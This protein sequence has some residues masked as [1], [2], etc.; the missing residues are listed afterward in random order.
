MHVRRTKKKER[1][2]KRVSPFPGPNPT[3][4]LTLTLTLS[5]TLSPNHLA[6]KLLQTTIPTVQ[7]NI[8]YH[9]NIQQGA[10]GLCIINKS[11]LTSRLVKL[12][13]DV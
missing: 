4:T 5:L 1:K 9:M 3:L 6:N 7:S 8:F 10:N 12:H 13:I 11:K 2:K